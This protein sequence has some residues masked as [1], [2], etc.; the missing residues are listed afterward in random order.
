MPIDPTISLQAGNPTGGSGGTNSA[1]NDPL[2]MVSEF[3]NI[4]NALNKNKEFQQEFAARQLAGKIMSTA[5]SVDEGLAQILK[6]P[7]A[8]FMGQY[9][10]QINTSRAQQRQ[11]EKTE[12]EMTQSALT[13]AKK[14]AFP[15]S[16]VQP[17]SLDSNLL[18]NLTGIPDSIKE[19]V[20]AGINAVRTSVL[21]G[22][23]ADTS[24][25]TPAQRETYTQRAVA[26]AMQAGTSLDEVH[27]IVGQ[28]QNI[29]LPQGE[30]P[31][32]Q[33]G[34]MFGIGKPIMQTGNPFLAGAPAGTVT[35]PSGAVIPHP[36]IIPGQT[37]QLAQAPPN[38]LGAGPQ[39][40]IEPPSGDVPKSGIGTPLMAPK[41]APQQTGFGGVPVMDKNQVK[42]AEDASERWNKEQDK[43][44]S[45]SD[46]RA[47]LAAM[48]RDLNE[49]ARQAFETGNPGFLGPGAGGETRLKIGNW[50][51]T[52][53][54][55]LGGG[56]V[57]DPSTISS[58]ES[59]LKQS[60][61]AGLKTDVAAFGQ[62]RIAF[63]TVDRV[64]K[65]NPGLDNSFLGSK[66]VNDSL[67]VML[68]RMEDKQ[69]V[70][71]DWKKNHRGNMDGFDEWFNA[72]YPATKY[73]EKALDRNGLKS[74]G[75]FQKREY[76][77]NALKSGLITPKI[78]REV[79]KRDFDTIIKDRLPGEKEKE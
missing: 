38:P 76:V 48:N 62:A 61:T 65:A 60:I 17:S 13:F 16:I 35:T 69:K 14:N 57:L 53:S 8:P 44:A 34:Y 52:I 31:G 49:M 40:Y 19:R 22:L 20:M 9:V 63:N 4:Q 21:D 50:A 77:I 43:F 23:P 24:K 75:T 27:A 10:N 39:S 15:A 36:P 3:A 42:N 51:N 2:K 58:M 32:F 66:L 6:S 1:T 78:A 41:M 12:M 64:Q 26:Q 54:G 67:D 47:S 7:A 74:D 33:P 5:G 28:N 11:T 79:L 29:K 71:V 25:W 45:A 72:N 70:G 56:A 30:I 59:L 37:D 55:I 73:M 68:E 18:G 46:S